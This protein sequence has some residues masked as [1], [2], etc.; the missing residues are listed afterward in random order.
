M[1][2][3]YWA[4]GLEPFYL[5]GAFARVIHDTRSADRSAPIAGSA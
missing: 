4:S 5:E 1:R 2:L 3:A